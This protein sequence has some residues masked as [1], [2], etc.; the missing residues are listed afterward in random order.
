MASAT[1]SIGAPALRADVTRRDRAVVA[2]QPQSSIRTPT[3]IS[4]RARGSN[5]SPVSQTRV[6]ITTP[7]E[8]GATPHS[9]G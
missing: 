1:V 9:V 6:T 2:S 8:T 4:T 7:Y 5:V 3:A